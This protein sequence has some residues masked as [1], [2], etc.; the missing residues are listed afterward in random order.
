ML[1]IDAD[2]NDLMLSTRAV[3]HAM[4]VGLN[5]GTL[6]RF[7][8]IAL[9]SLFSST[10]PAVI[11]SPVKV[12]LSPTQPVVTITVT[13][14]SDV[15]MT[16]QNQVLAWSQINGQDQLEESF[17]LLV[18]P[19]I[20]EIAPRANQIFRV[21]QRRQSV[22]V[23]E[24]AYRLVLD[25]ISG[26]A[27]STG[28]DGVNF[29]F[30]HRLP[31]FVAGTGTR[32]PQLQLSPCPAVTEKSC[33]RLTN[34]GDSYTQIQQLMVIGGNWQHDLGGGTRILAGA[35]MQWSFLSPP[36]EI[37]HLTVTVNTHVGVTIFNL[38]NPKP[39]SIPTDSIPDEL[40]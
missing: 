3:N 14:D 35:W 26:T 34:D 36:L 32:G 17:D 33:F 8:V 6:Y 22:T 5:R 28:V 4:V 30:S 25:D 12:E 21:T 2:R 29:V 27:G 20:A 18:A 13:N 37:D 9:A 39:L 11:I 38:S 24:R 1:T 31:V 15:P 40:F 23:T 7:L 10:T 19:V 16:L